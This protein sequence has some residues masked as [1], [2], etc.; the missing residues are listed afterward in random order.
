MNRRRVQNLCL[1]CGGQGHYQASCENPESKLP[2]KEG[3]IKGDSTHPNKD[4]M[5]AVFTPDGSND[6]T[7]SGTGILRVVFSVE[8]RDE[9]QNDW[10]L[11]EDEEVLPFSL[12]SGNG[13]GAPGRK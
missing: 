8:D 13:V 5:R 2:P 3:G 11:V 9:S 7:N 1:R 12:D 4:I 6:P 10:K